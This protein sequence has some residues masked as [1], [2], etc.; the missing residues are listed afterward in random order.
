MVEVIQAA[1]EKFLATVRPITALRTGYKPDTGKII[2]SEIVPMATA[3]TPTAD[4]R[5]KVLMI[6][7]GPPVSATLLGTVTNNLT[8]DCTLPPTGSQSIS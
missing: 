2:Y 6:A 8:R 4:G 3:G 7:N 5:E 1:P